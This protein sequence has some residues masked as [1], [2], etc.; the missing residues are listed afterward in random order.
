MNKMFE[1]F[2]NDSIIYHT[3]LFKNKIV[4]YADNH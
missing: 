3:K 1:V 2:R 4:L